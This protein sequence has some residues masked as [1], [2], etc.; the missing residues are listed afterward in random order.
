MMN[1]QRESEKDECEDETDN[2]CKHDTPAFFSCIS[3]PRLSS[4]I[5]IRAVKRRPQQV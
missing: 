5:V 4:K 3:T 1:S 2:Y